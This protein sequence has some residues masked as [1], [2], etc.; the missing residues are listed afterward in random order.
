MPLQNSVGRKPVSV[1]HLHVG[2]QAPAFKWL[3]PYERKCHIKLKDVLMCGLQARKLLLLLFQPDLKLRMNI[4]LAMRDRF[5]V[6]K[7]ILKM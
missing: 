7:G 5:L 4:R 1:A 6:S 3:N 2:R